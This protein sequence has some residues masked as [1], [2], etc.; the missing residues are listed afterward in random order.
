MTTVSIVGASQAGKTALAGAIGKKGNVSDITYYEFN[1][2]ASPMTIL[3]ASGYPDSAKSLVTAL[4]LSDIV[5]FC[6]PPEGL[7]AV[8]GECIV[9]LSLLKKQHGFVVIT[10]SDTSDPF[11]L[12]EAEAKI[13]K[14]LSGTALEGWEFL[15]VSSKAFEG[16]DDLRDA[17]VKLGESVTHNLDEPVRVVVDQFFDVTGIGCVILGVVDRGTVNVKD[18][19]LVYPIEKPLDVRSIQMHDVDVKASPAGSRVG[20]ACKGIQS[21]MFSRGQIISLPESEKMAA[22]FV[23]DMDV[24]PFTAGFGVGDILH[25][26]V[27]LQSSPVKVS[28]IEENGAAVDAAKGGK[29]Y[30]VRVEADKQI[31]YR[32]DDLFLLCN[33]DV[34]KQRFVASGCVG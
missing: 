23:L 7:D 14:M 27:G 5:L 2:G 20:L 10:K 11:M 8:A 25:L 16:I 9:A 24:T 18:K 28:G 34:A 12:G 15:R 17:V 32:D 31:A 1:K 26:Y 3:D 22:G 21:R 13:K 33:L 30:T 19:L 29:K 6:V 4:N